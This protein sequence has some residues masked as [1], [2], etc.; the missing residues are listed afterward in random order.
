M[1]PVLD[2]NVLTGYLLGELSEAEQTRVEEQLFFDNESYER[3]QALKA[4]MTDQYVRETLAPKRREVFARR[5]LTTEAGREDA[6]FARALDGVL[7]A[8]N[9]TRA[10][11]ASEQSR[12][13][14][15]QSLL[16]FFSPSS[17]WKMAMAASL[18]ILFIGSAWLLVERQRLIERLETANRER[19]VAQSEARKGALLETELS[20]LNS[21]NKELDEKLRQ[22]SKDLDGTRQNLD[23]ILR[24]S[25]AASAVGA[26]LSLILVP[27]AGRGNE[28]V[29]ELIVNP[30]ARTVQLQ[31]L[32]EPGVTGSRYRAEVRIKGGPLIYRQDRLRSRRTADGNAVLVNIPADRL[33]DGRYEVDLHGAKPDVLSDYEFDIIRRF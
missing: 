30:R 20:R 25:R 32:L 28:R 12:V 19:D 15:W 13:S 29:E 17:G 23:R 10:P 1:P 3:L 5:F 11:A 21:E 22:T 33:K 14:W 24:Q 31:L 18:T 6:L 16:A 4:E 9:T 8:E 2:D 7:R 27:G 26:V